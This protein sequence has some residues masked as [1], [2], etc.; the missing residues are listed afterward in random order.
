MMDLD[1][2]AGNFLYGDLPPG[3]E[4]LGFYF[5]K[6]EA[7]RAF[8]S[9]YFSFSELYTKGQFKIF[10]DNFCDHTGISCTTMWIR[11]LLS[12]IKKIEEELERASK[13]FDLAR[14]GE[15]KSGKASF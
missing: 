5:N 11:K 12:R 4:Y 2:I 10:Y 1:F 8:V 14:V 6:G 15:I 7:E 13:E 9:Y 3:K